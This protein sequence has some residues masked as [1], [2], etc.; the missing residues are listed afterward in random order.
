MRQA[1]RALGE[2]LDR[3]QESPR[4]RLPELSGRPHPQ[5]HLR[6]R[7]GGPR[8]R[9]ERGVD[10]QAAA[11]TPAPDAARGRKAAR[12][13]R[14]RPEK[15]RPQSKR[16]APP[17]RERGP[18]RSSSIAKRLKHHSKQTARPHQAEGRARA[19]EA[20]KRVNRRFRS[21]QRAG[22]AGHALARANSRRAQPLPRLSGERGRAALRRAR[23]RRSARIRHLG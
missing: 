18:R 11:G 9:D 22:Q 21:R 20:D 17:D 6:Q 23:R 13:G 12:A 7:E 14:R 3:S 4:R 1:S 16:A 15:M 5:D 19:I 8:A 2:P 10:G